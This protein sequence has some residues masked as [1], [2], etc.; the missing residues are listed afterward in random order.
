MVRGNDGE[1]AEIGK[2]GDVVVIG[3]KPPNDELLLLKVRLGVG[4]RDDELV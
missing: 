4:K 1:D 2:D 3:V